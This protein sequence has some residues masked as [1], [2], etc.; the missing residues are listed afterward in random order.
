[1]IKFPVFAAP[2]ITP[3][4]KPAIPKTPVIDQKKIEQDTA[5]QNSVQSFNAAGTVALNDSISS[6]FGTFKVF[7][8]PNPYTNPNDLHYLVVFYHKNTKETFRIH[9]TLA[10]KFLEIFRNKKC[11]NFPFADDKV[12]LINNRNAISILAESSLNWEESTNNVTEKKYFNSVDI[13]KG[14]EDM[15]INNENSLIAYSEEYNFPNETIVFENWKKHIKLVGDK[16]NWGKSRKIRS[17]GK[18]NQVLFHETAGQGNLSFGGIQKDGDTY[19]IPH[20]VINNL[21]QSNKGNIL[22][23][24][25]IAELVYHGETLNNQAVGIEFVNSP[26][27]AYQTKEVNGKKVPDYTKPIF[28]LDK[29]E[30]GIYLQTK[31]GGFSKL[32]IPFEFNSEKTSQN[33]EL[34]IP[35]NKLI[36]LATLKTVIG[37]DKKKVIEENGDNIIIKYCKSERFDHLATLVEFLIKNKII[38]GIENIKDEKYWQVVARKEGELVYLFQHSYKRDT[39]NILH[40][41]VD[42]IDPGFFYAFTYRRTCRW[43]FASLIFVFKVC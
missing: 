23:F 24:A 31:L 37:A 15:Q 34:T 33:F 14:N 2:K 18:P 39:N 41:G 8:Y 27:E 22:Q 30:K 38:K 20:F 36:N 21:D 17:L 4:Q 13:L 43:K 29:S 40:F 42:I 9:G 32:F 16:Q 7:Q 3:P 11:N 25:D 35:K 19:Y 1:M 26:I 5:I 10:R 12:A 6:D 28:N